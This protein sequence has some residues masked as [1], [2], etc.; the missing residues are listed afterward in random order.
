MMTSSSRQQA[1]GSAQQLWQKP[2]LAVNSLTASGVEVKQEPE[3]KPPLCDEDEDSRNSFEHQGKGSSL[4]LMR[5]SS[6][7]YC[8]NSTNTAN[9]NSSSN[10]QLGH[11]VSVSPGYQVIAGVL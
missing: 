7:S 3:E 10:S 2:H 8:L 11:F 6:S 1:E 4:G 9:N 5:S